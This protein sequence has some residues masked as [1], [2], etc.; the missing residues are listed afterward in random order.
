MLMPKNR[1]PV[2]LFRK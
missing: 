1:Q 2:M